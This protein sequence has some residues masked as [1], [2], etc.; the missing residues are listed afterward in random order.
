MI[1]YEHHEFIRTKDVTTY[2]HILLS[3]VVS[4][5]AC[6][7]GD[8]GSIPGL[9]ANHMCRHGLV[10]YDVCLTR[11]RSWVRFPLL[12]RSFCFF[13]GAAWWACWWLLCCAVPFGA[14]ALS[15]CRRASRFGSLG[16]FV[17]S[18]CVGRAGWCSTSC[19]LAARCRRRGRP[20]LPRRE[21]A[22]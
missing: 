7:A 15:L 12:I 5:P 13:F 2:K 19:Y 21:A 14:V 9:G 6:H 16:L 1:K 17:W 20:R 11:R 4:I 22:A 10:G 18:V 3:I 8:P